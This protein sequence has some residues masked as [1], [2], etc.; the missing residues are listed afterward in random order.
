MWH[1]N[2][3]NL[4]Q[5]A[6]EHFKNRRYREAIDCID[7]ALEIDTQTLGSESK[8]VALHLKNR[9][10]ALICLGRN[11]E[12]LRN[13][14]KALSIFKKVEGPIANLAR[15]QFCLGQPE[16]KAEAKKNIEEAYQILMQVLGKNH[17]DTFTIKQFKDSAFR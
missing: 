10:M 15:A 12:A 17:P 13:Y 16:T 14:E 4:R 5:Q 9:G 8:E 11:N 1:I 2:S 7:K 6:T 3:D